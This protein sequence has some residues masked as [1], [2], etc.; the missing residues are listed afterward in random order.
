MS[1]TGRQN[2]DTV[3]PSS[4]KK[5]QRSLWASIRETLVW[6]VLLLFCWFDYSHIHRIYIYIYVF[7]HMSVLET[8]YNFL[9]KL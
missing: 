3:L 1:T 9:V 2:V 7:F 4:A 5:K 8:C 6:V